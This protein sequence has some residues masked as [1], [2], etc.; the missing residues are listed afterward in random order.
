MYK[1]ETYYNVF[2]WHAN[3]FGSLHG[4]IYM[5]W[6]ID[7][8]GLLM[9]NVSRGNYLLA[10]VDYIYLF[11]PARVGDVIRV[12]AET[13]AGWESSVEIKV[14]ACIKRGEKEELGAL[15]LTTYV[16]V[17]ENGRPRKLP[18]K[19][20]SDEEANKRRE[21]RIE[22]KKKD[23]LD[24]EDLLPG[25]SFGKSYIRTI[26]PEHGFGNGILYAGKMYTMLD[27]AL[28]IVAKLYS[29]GNVFTGSA[30]AANFLSPVR[31][32]DILEIQAAIEYT[33]NTSLDVGAKVFAINHYTGEKRLVTRTVFS[34]VAIDENAKPKPIQ[35]ITPITEKEKKI[36]EERLKEREERIK[37]SKSLQETELCQ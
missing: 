29:R 4:G 27:E 6:L 7:T 36:F 24:Q 10:S 25:M 23:V 20:G 35:K 9:S 26:Y 15:G 17:D 28:A 22:K 13:T 3:H 33:G 5:N 34:F 8:S 19:I 18:V 37:L 31:I 2:P 21:K 16:A 1:I 14:K 32:G 12:A 30:G 11:K